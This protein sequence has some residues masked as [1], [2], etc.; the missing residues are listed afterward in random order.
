MRYNPHIGDIVVDGSADRIFPKQR[1]SPYPK[2]QEKFVVADVRFQILRNVGPSK[3][4]K[5]EVLFGLFLDELIKPSSENIKE[6]L[7]IVVAEMALEAF[8]AVAE[9]RERFAPDSIFLT[10]FLQREE[11]Y[12]YRKKQETL[13]AECNP[14]DPR[15]VRQALLLDYENEAFGNKVG[16]LTYNQLIEKR[17]TASFQ[18]EAAAFVLGTDRIDLLAEEQDR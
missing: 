4:D 17:I 7:K 16:M 13:L 12:F 9:E 6:A 8:D 18:D 10:P 1:P 15:V 11:E 14:D 3:E 2:T 5:M